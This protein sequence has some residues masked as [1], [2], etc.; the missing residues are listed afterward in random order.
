MGY[1]TPDQLDAVANAVISRI[2]YA[3]NIRTLFM[4]NIHP[5]FRLLLAADPA[6]M[7]QLEL[8]LAALNDTG[9]LVDGTIPLESWLDKAARRLKPF[10]EESRLIQQVQ[11]ALAAKTSST[12][13]IDNGPPPSPAV[14]AAVELEKFVHDNDMVS[15]AFLQ[16]GWKAGN[17]I[18]RIRITR[19]EN[20]QPKEQSVGEPATSLGTCWMLT[21]DLVITNHHVIN[22]RKQ[23]EA[24]A[25]ADD[26]KKQA[27]NA[28]VEF[29]YNFNYVEGILSRI[30]TLEAYDRTLDFAILRM[31]KLIDRPLPRLLAEKI[32][33][34]TGTS[35]AVN[36]IQ[37]PFGQAKK[38]GLR[39]NHIYDAAS[40]RIRYFTDTEEGSSGS[41]VFND[42]WQVIAL[43]RASSLVDNVSYN[44]QT[45]A[46]VNEGVQLYAIMEHLKQH[47][48]ALAQEIEAAHAPAVLPVTAN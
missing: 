32:M 44:G 3:P 22:A 42:N 34:D 25:S 20:G 10:P 48:P 18:A 4:K 27:E 43:H 6:E 19:Y 35:Q 7:I 8:D 24:P 38:V 26:F 21:K 46:W 36:I 17:A 15:F 13:V 33:L 45:T 29:D 30:A 1:L 47:A 2:G 12:P 11:A 28:L 14:V 37:H 31:P 23:I 39:N 5:G 9:R 41:A 16:E 40:P